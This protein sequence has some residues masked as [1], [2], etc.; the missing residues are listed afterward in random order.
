ML[1]YPSALQKNTREIEEALQSFVRSVD[2]PEG[3]RD[4]MAWSLLGGGKRLRPSLLLAVRTLFPVQEPDAMPTA[5]ALEIIHTYSLIHDDLPAM[6]DDDLRR[7]RPANHKRFGE[8]VAILAGDALLTEAFALVT[9]DL[10]EEHAALGLRLVR[11]LAAAA[12]AGG[13]VGGQVLDIQ[14]TEMRISRDALERLHGMKTGRLFQAAARCGALLGGADEDGLAAVTLYADRLGHAFQVAD[15][16]LDVTGT[17]EALGKTVGKDARQAKTTYVSL[18]GLDG[19][20]D[21]A[22][23]LREEAVEALSCFGAVAKPLRELAAF[24]VGRTS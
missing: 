23:G 1:G 20:H 16:I 13:M 15:D 4:A 12:G 6:D 19:A 17:T 3:L 11:E 24:A 10:P 18:L 5:C 7:G 2:A 9:R 14:A 22:E 21:L 8:A